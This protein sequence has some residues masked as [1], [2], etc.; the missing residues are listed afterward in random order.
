MFQTLL[1]NRDPFVNVVM[2]LLQKRFSVTIIYIFW[3]DIV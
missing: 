3:I 1:G 2:I